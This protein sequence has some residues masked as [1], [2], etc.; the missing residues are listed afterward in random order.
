MPSRDNGGRSGGQQMNRRNKSNH[1]KGRIGSYNKKGSQGGN[2]RDWRKPDNRSHHQ[3]ADD[4]GNKT[5][6][7]RLEIEYSCGHK[8]K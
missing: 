6:H 3:N 2:G 7:L 4:R 5:F 8:N 1:G